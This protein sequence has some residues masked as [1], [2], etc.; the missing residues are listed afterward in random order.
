[1][2]WWLNRR[3]PA[4]SSNSSEPASAQARAGCA[5][6]RPP[7]SACRGRCR[8]RA[9]GA[10]GRTGRRGSCP[11]CRARRSRPA[12]G[13][14]CSPRAPGR[15]RPSCSKQLG[16][17]PLGPDLHPVGDAAV[18]QRL[19]DRLVGVLELGVLADDR[20]PHLALGV[21]DA[22]DHVLPLR[23]GSA[24]APARSRRRRAPPGRAPPCDRRAAPRRSSR[25]SCAAITASG[26]TLQKSASF[27]RSFGGIGFS[28]RQTSTSGAMPIARSSLTEC[29]VG[30]VFSS[31]DAAR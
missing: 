9:P 19:G 26:R 22:V 15:S 29:W 3:S 12:P 24:A 1:M 11:R 5:R 7:P 17:E 6:P 28:E 21:V 8:G 27:S 18:G 31:P 13:S 30:L 25:R 20:D 23:R 4:S 2:T 10:R 14:R 16:V